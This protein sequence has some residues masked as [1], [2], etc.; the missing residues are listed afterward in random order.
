MSGG[1]QILLGVQGTN[2]GAPVVTSPPAI[3]GTTSIGS[4]VSAQ[5]AVVT[6]SPAP[7][8][9][10]REWLINSVPIPGATASTYTIQASDLGKQLVVSETWSN[11]NGFASAASAASTV[12]KGNEQVFLFA[13]GDATWTVPADWNSANNT[14][15][16]IGAGGRASPGTS[17]YDTNYA[18]FGGGGG[19]YAAK[20][21]VVLTPGQVL[22]AFVSPGQQGSSLLGGARTYTGLRTPD[23]TTWLVMAEDGDVGSNGRV[24]QSV[25]DVLFAGGFSGSGNTGAFVGLGGGGAGGPSGAGG[26][27]AQ[28]P[29]AN[30]VQPGVGGGGGNGGTSSLSYTGTPAYAGTNGGNNASGVGA[31]V[32]SATVAPTQAFDGGGGAGGAAGTEGQIPTDYGVVGGG[33]GSTDP[34]WSDPVGPSWAPG[35]GPGAGGGGAGGVMSGSVI[36]GGPGQAG[37]YGG[38][39][40]GSVQQSFGALYYAQGAP[41]MIL[42]EYGGNTTIVPPSVVTAPNIAA[43]PWANFPVAYVRGTTDGYPRPGLARVQWRANGVDIPGAWFP[44]YIPSNFDIGKTLT[45]VEYWLNGPTPVL[46]ESNGVVVGTYAATHSMTSAYISSDNA[47]GY[48]VGQGS[49]APSTFKGLAVARLLQSLDT[50]NAILFE[51]TLNANTAIPQNFV[52]G[53]QLKLGAASEVL[54]GTRAASFNSGTTI[55]SKATWLWNVLP[56]RLTGNAQVT[57]VTIT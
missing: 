26:N 54:I 34:I 37:L 41:G 18:A 30:A 4:T 24:S 21:N 12:T 22:K 38:G 20:V 32:G 8:L 56:A 13:G 53:L 43:T 45:V 40:G 6:G 29:N 35:V 2:A 19:A 42:I 57:E 16:V 1:Q 27:S 7:T 10:A 50:S 46:V 48:N 14:I 47:F 52:G 44:T 17:T 25:G 9:Y 31:G 23:D 15:H 55:G 49:L 33:W 3:L 5:P 28:F 36:F 39:G 51:V 11:T